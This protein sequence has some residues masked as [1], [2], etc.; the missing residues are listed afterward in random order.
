MTMIDLTKGNPAKGMLMFAL[1]VAFGNLFQLFYSLADTRIVGSTL[2][3]EALAAVGATTSISTLLIGFMNG[4]TNG[5]AILIAQRFGAG[6]QDE[7]RRFGALSFGLGILMS[8]CLAI[9]SIAGLGPV[10][11]LLNVPESLAENARIY[12]TIILLGIPSAMA[13]NGCAG[14]LRAVGDT[15]A[16]LAFLVLSSLLNVG[17]DLVFILQF[18]MGVGGA[19]WATVLSQ[20]VSALLSFFY[21]WKTYPFFRFRWADFAPEKTRVRRLLSSGLSMALMMSLVFFGTLALQCAINTFGTNTIVA[22]T[23]ARKITEF[24]MLPF[25]VMSVTMATYCG[26]NLGAGKEERIRQG[27]GCALGLTWGWSLLVI[28]LSYTAAPA[29]IYLVTASREPEVINTASLYLKID[30][31]FYF[32]PAAIA[33]LRNALQGIGDH[34]TPIVSSF[35]EL[36]GKVA[37]AYFLTPVFKYMGIIAAEPIVWLLMV[38]P[39]VIRFLRHPALKR[40]FEKREA[41]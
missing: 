15:K 2:G 11:T 5:F 13:Y 4:L 37:A 31:L 18:H 7:V 22:H 23:G 32:A 14:I 27:V 25:S 29:L 1:P 40:D 17:L 28:L 6:E 8:V 30:T 38:I 16:P 36:A 26:Q 33:V 39:L 24:Y 9:L 3:A 10:F 35:I 19:A 20:T 41:A 34:V 12:I 21:M